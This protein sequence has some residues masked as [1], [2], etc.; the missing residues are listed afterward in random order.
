MP[1]ITLD[2]RS[3][4]I[5]NAVISCYITT[6][7]PVGSRTL[8][9]KYK[10]TVSPAT[11]RNIMADLEEMGY[12]QHPH[13]SAGRIPTEM[14]YRFYVDALTKAKS[15]ADK[16]APQIKE[17]SRWYSGGSKNADDLFKSLCRELSA[18]SQYIGVITT[19]KW[20]NIIYKHIKFIC[21][22]ENQYLVIFVTQNGI[23]QQRLIEVK[24]AYTQEQLDQMA[25]CLNDNL[26]GQPLTQVRKKIL[27]LMAQ[28]KDA[29]NRLLQDAVELSQGVLNNIAESKLYVEGELNMLN[30][31]E[32]ADIDKMKA[33]FRAFEEKHHLIKLLDKC[34]ND[35]GVNIFIGSENEADRMRDC[36]LVTATYR[37]HNQVV[38]TLGVIGPVRMPYSQVISLVEYAAKLLSEIL[39]KQ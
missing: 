26:N 30:Q 10:L 4:L 15:K 6:A 20:Q 2:E 23:A 22:R 29:Y 33:I 12:L 13:T 21:L 5:L 37:D 11:V 25:R 18:I 38:G 27:E 19:P 8:W 7:D 1:D 35:D 36:S 34:L 28:E 31:P 3:Q 39:S 9:K 32:F 17:L 14:G 16:I 24:E